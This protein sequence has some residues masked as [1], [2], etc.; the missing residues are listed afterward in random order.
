MGNL[1]VALLVIAISCVYLGHSIATQVSHD[2]RAITIDGQRRIIMSGSI[3]YPRSTAQMWP[4]LIQKAK[5]GGLNTIESYVFWNAHE[6]RRRQYNFNGN[7]DLIRFIKTVHQAGLYFILRIGP[8]ACAEWNYG[9]F[10]VWLHQIP[11]IQLRTDNQIFKDEMQNFTALIV[12]LVKQ[13]KLLAHQGGP[14]ILTQ[15]IF[16]RRPVENEYGNV[17]APYGEAGKKYVDWCSK[18]AVSLDVGVPW[19]MCQQGDAPQP[20]INT[21]NGFYC[22]KFT[23]NN[24]SSPKMWTENWVG[25]FKAWGGKD[26]HRP[27]EDVAMGVALFFKN[28]GTLQNYYMYHGGTNFGRTSGGPYITTSYDYDAPLDEYGNLRQPKWGH[29][30]QLHEVI[31]SMENALVYGEPTTTDYGNGV[32][33]TMYK[34]ANGTAGCFIANTNMM[35]ATVTF[36][37]NNYTIPPWS[38][39]ILNDCK[40]VNYNTAKL[41]VNDRKMTHVRQ[42]TTQT[43]IMVQKPNDAENEPA[44]L[45]WLWQG[46]KIKDTVKGKRGSFTATN[47]LEQLNTTGDTSDYLWYM[48]RVSVSKKDPIYG[49]KVTLRVNTTGHVLHAFFNGK[50]VAPTGIIGGPVQLVAEGNITKDLS[51]D[52]WSY[53]VGLNGETR[54]IYLDAPS[55]ASRWKSEALPLNRSMTWYKTTFKA[56]LGE[57]PV[58]VD[59]LGMGKGEAWV[60]GQSIGRYWPSFDAPSDGCGKCD[61]RG[62]YD[63]K[64]CVT[65]CGEPSQ[66]WYHVPRSFLRDGDNTLILFEEFGGNPTTVNFQTVTVGTACGTAEEGS[67]LELSCQGGRTFS[68]IQFAGYGDPQGTCG[69]FQNGA[70]DSA[71]ALSAVQ[72]ECLGKTRCS[73]LVGESALEATTCGADVVKKLSVQAVC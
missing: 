46:E 73:I 12:D 21:C 51:T 69:S 14:I 38:V 13:E 63:S 17:M 19:I 31:L 34:P 26:P 35:A 8:Y 54:Q 45:K 60:N 25:W 62:N 23:P 2:A 49:N 44:A 37:G 11:G 9:G 32:S 52:Q 20:M 39:S 64:K 24:P 1:Q 29:L 61:Y 53:K 71:N 4:D 55:Q 66:R 6:P 56:P 27:A 58:V 59:L 18:M 65:G 33:A 15:V 16:A 3:H 68:Q 40:N 48:T 42:I 47:L 28:G 72:K 70:C 30:K 7:N 50:R 67:T 43:S 57:E 5:D 41:E 22:H 36:Q 10:P